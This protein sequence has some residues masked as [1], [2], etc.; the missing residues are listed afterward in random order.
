MEHIHT[1]TFWAA[2]LL[3]VFTYFMLTEDDE[4]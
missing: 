2:V 3:S 1:I 4:D